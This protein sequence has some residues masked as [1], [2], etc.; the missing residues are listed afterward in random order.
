MLDEAGKS[1]N[2][3]TSWLALLLRKLTRKLASR[4]LIYTM[5]RLTSSIAPWKVFSSS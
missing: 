3:L 1:T 5:S 4:H 2:L